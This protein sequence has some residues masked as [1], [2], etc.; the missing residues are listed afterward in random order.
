MPIQLRRILLLLFS[1]VVLFL[2]ARHFLVPESFGELGHYRANAIKEIAA[3][4][5]KYVGSEA[6]K[7]CHD[8]EAGLL[9]TGPHKNMKCETCHGPGYKH[10]DS[11]EAA[12]IIKPSGR[13]FC[14][15]CHAKNPAR[16][17]SNIKQ[18]DVK[19]HNIDEDQCFNCH[20][21]HDPWNEMR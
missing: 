14:A 19:E 4:Q 13:D 8:D 21:P 17:E 7:E 15:K 9:A 16:S 20:N 5:P 12:D 1:F 6:C 18:V 11:N 10:V 3:G 2:V